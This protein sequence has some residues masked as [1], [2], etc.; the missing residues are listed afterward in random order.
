MRRLL[1]ADLRGHKVRSFLTIMA[2]ALA[3]SLVVS[4]TSGFRSITGATRDSMSQFYGAADV[5]FTPFDSSIGYVTAP[6]IEAVRAD[7]RVKAVKRRLG[8]RLTPFNAAGKPAPGIQPDVMGIE[9]GGEMGHLMSPMREGRWFTAQEA[10]ATVID[11]TLASDLEL[12]LGDYVTLGGAEGQVRLKITGIISRVVSFDSQ[13][14]LM[15]APIDAVQRIIGRTGQVDRLMVDLNSSVDTEQFVAS[16]KEKLKAHDPPVQIRSIASRQ[17]VFDKNM[18]G[19]ELLS[20]IGGSISMVAAAFIIFSALSMGVTERTRILGMMRAIGAERLQIASLVVKEGILLAGLGAILGVLLGFLWIFILVRVFSHLF[21]SGLVISWLGVVFAMVGALLA[22]LAASLLPAWHASRLK[23]L[24]AMGRAAAP[25][26]GLAIKVCGLLGMILIWV[27]SFF[28]FA[29]PLKESELTLYAHVLLGIPCLMISLFLLAPMLV[30]GFQKVLSPLLCRLMGLE[31]GLLR[32]QV[33][34]GVWRSAGTTAALTVGLTALVV[35]QTHGNTMLNGWQ[36]PHRFPDLCILSESGASEQ[37]IDEIRKIKG[38]D[39]Q[40][41]SPVGIT[42]PNLAAQLFGMIRYWDKPQATVFLAFDVKTAFG[43][44]SNKPDAG[45]I[46]LEFIDGTAE[47]AG[48]LLARGGHVLVSEEYRKLRKLGVGDKIELLSPTN[49]KVPFTIAGVIRPIGLDALIRIIGLSRE[50]ETWTSSCVIGTL[51][52][53]RA[54][55][56]LRNVRLIVADLE[57][58]KDKDAARAAVQAQLEK[59]SLRAFDANLA[60]QF[61]GDLF[62]KILNLVSAV[63]FAA[64]VVAS[65]GVMN[66]IV[67]SVRSRRWQLGVF[68]SL[69]L[70]RGA[71]A[72]LIIS[73]SMI[74]GMVACALGVSA[75]LLL[76][77]NAREMADMLLGYSPPLSPRWW[78]IGLGVFI[79]M[80]VSILASIFPAIQVARAE[81]L[82][83]LQAGR[84]SS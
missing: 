40:R 50:V 6:V 76:A 8:T 53:A 43:F 2:V 27:D 67:A 78:P 20:F 73:E 22:A 44:G 60:K 14:S 75:G 32:Q 63:A 68:R 45:M 7:P 39:P 57:P 69:G 26:S 65:F 25:S 70:T 37:T 17:E 56:G 61:I 12:H 55:L 48:I 28:I 15:Y 35:I 54:H 31:P 16:W 1:L 38:L 9:V 19:L 13:R 4:M 33:G 36:L 10:E 3:V 79:T 30:L 11:A 84:A 21:T 29:N 74:L 46:G 80:A 81:P 34:G 51:E 42:T 49:Q 5:V 62:G 23:P 59:K 82:K 52:D 41:I 72:R 71:L 66:T 58:S 83:L 64:I 77:F 47:Q 18:R 24:D